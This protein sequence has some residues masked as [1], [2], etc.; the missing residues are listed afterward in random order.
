MQMNISTRQLRAFLSLT[1]QRSFTRAAA[2][3]HL[4]QPAFSALIRSLEEALEQRLF[5]RST[6]HVELT[7]EG[8][9]FEVAARRV[10]AEFDGAL[11]GARDYAARR[12]GRAMPL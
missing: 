6:R 1:E 9:E 8:R 10:L 5:D 2:L 12:R 7:T 11:A 4:S 3:T